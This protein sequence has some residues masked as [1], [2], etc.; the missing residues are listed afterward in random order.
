MINAVFSILTNLLGGS[1]SA[2]Y[3]TLSAFDIADREIERD[4]ASRL[5]LEDDFLDIYDPACMHSISISDEHKRDVFDAG[6]PF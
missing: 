6:P 2:D 3:E 1:T 5:P 4:R